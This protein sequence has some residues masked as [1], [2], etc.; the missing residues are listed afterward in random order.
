MAV[1]GGAGAREVGRQGCEM[2]NPKG[3][4]YCG[5]WL[6]KKLGTGDGENPF[7]AAPFRFRGR[8]QWLPRLAPAGEAPHMLWKFIYL[9][10]GPPICFESWATPGSLP[11]R[12]HCEI[13]A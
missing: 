11:A 2:E 12:I 5:V 9:P 1:D 7:P 8:G 10:P 3:R 4:E 6:G 13:W